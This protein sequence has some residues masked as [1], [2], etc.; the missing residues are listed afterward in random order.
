[1]VTD[2]LSHDSW[3]AA[4]L[5]ISPLAAAGQVPCQQW[6]RGFLHNEVDGRVG[7]WKQ[8]TANPINLFLA[9]SGI[10]GCAVF[11]LTRV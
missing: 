1:M 10:N 9:R 5:V 8:K 2:F 11:S 6:I 3:G 7:F 4:S